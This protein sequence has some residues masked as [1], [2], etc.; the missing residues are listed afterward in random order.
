MDGEPEIRR[1][2]PLEPGGEPF[3]LVVTTRHGGTVAT[4]AV[5]RQKFQRRIGGARFVLAG[6]LKTESADAEVAHLSSGMTHK[7]AAA[8]IDAD[9]QKSVIVTTKAVINDSEAKTAILVEHIRAVRELDPGVIFGP[10]MQVPEAIQNAV[11]EVDGLL[12]H[13]TGLSV[14]HG[15]LSID[16]RGY[17]AE[18]VMEGVRTVFPDEW[19]GRMTATVQGFGAVGAHMARLLNRAGVRVR[20]VSN[21]RGMVAA[22]DGGA[23]DVEALF[24]A[25][26]EG[27]DEAVQRFA[28]AGESAGLRWSREPDALYEE[29]CD[30]FVPAARTAVLAMPDQLEHVREMENPDAQDVTRFA[31]RTGVRMVAEGANAPLTREAERYLEARGV[32]VLP[33]YIANCGGLIGCWV[34]WERREGGS[35]PSPEEL[36]ALHGDAL[37][38]VR[39]TVRRNVERLLDRRQ[40]LRELADGMVD[41]L[42]NGGSAGS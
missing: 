42:L 33:D 13:V 17:T 20:A 19:L 4:T 32:V 39:Q 21:A 34:E 41:D 18:G 25:W 2:Q 28:E 14:S 26:E 3:A 10:D 40:G 24:A 9:G 29:P 16:T 1:N 8:E 12:N 27:G 23:L 30:I 31:A 22:R 6:D 11:S 5:H 36:D 15:G 37:R 38:R 7:C 35:R